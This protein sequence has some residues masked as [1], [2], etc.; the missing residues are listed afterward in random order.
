MLDFISFKTIPFLTG[1]YKKP[2]VFITHMNYLNYRW[3]KKGIL[4]SKRYIKG[5]CLDIGS[6]NSPYK[7]YLINQI[8]EYIAVDKQETHKHMFSNS[9]E[10][11]KDADIKNLPFKDNYAD[12]ILLTQVLE[13]IDDP[14]KAL[15]EVYRVLKKDG[16]LI[17]S[18]PFIYQTHAAPYDFYRF[19][20]FA[21][22]NI[23]KKY[24]FKEIEFIHQGFLGTTVVSIINGFVWEIASR[25]KFLRN[26]LLLPLLL[27]FF[28]ISNI[29]GLILDRI[30]NRNFTPNFWLILRK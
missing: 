1:E 23:I 5:V 10:K 2:D 26:T 18:V 19:S 14:F 25:N 27:M 15:D 24:E 30:E 13:H 12:T 6:G 7:K 16:I 28:S 3:L 11:F 4:N 29:L 22:R 20:E 9:K 8:D 17:L 21:L